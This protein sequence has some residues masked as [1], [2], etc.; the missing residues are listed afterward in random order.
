MYMID[1]TSNFSF[2]AL[3]NF[4]LFSSS[5]FVPIEFSFAIDEHIPPEC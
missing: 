3:L 4:S 1:A 5:S 2:V